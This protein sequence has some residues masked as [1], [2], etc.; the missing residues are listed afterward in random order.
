MCGLLHIVGDAKDTGYWMDF[1]RISCLILSFHTQRTVQ[2][3][4]HCTVSVCWLNWQITCKTENIKKE[5]MTHTTNSA[6]ST[7]PTTGNRWMK[8]MDSIKLRDRKTEQD[9]SLSTHTF[10]EVMIHKYVQWI[11]REDWLLVGRIQWKLLVDPKT[12]QRKR[13]TIIEYWNWYDYSISFKIKIPE[14]HLNVL[15]VRGSWSK[16]SQ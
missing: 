11:V 12:S 15:K 7:A 10:L 13:K 3:T 16:S 4:V 14:S 8:W 9:W 1:H 2:L 6:H 5:R